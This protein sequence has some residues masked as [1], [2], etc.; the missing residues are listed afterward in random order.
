MNSFLALLM[1]FAYLPPSEC[2]LSVCGGCEL[3]LQLPSLFI[4]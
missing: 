1:I 2:G 4:P 3:G